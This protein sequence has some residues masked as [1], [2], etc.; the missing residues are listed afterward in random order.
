MLVVIKNIMCTQEHN[1]QSC[2][3]GSQNNFAAK[4]R[5]FCVHLTHP[6]V[7][8]P[9]KRQMVQGG[10]FI[11]GITGGYFRGHLTSTARWSFYS[12]Y[13]RRGG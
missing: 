8:L 6:E 2:Y 7:D 9:S 1:N 3:V 12:W 11:V 5:Y 13:Q 4:L 10:P